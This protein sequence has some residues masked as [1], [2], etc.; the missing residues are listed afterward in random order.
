MVGKTTPVIIHDQ[1]EIVQRAQELSQELGVSIKPGFE[2]F[3]AKVGCEV[4]C[5]KTDEHEWTYIRKDGRCFP[6]M[7]SITALRNAEGNI[8]GFLGI[9]S[10]LTECKQPEAALRLLYEQRQRS[11]Q[12]L[13]LVM[14]LIPQAIW[15][16]DHDSRFLGYNH[17]FAQMVRVKSRDELINKTDYDIWTKEEADLFRA[18]DTRIMAQNRA[19]YNIVEPVSQHKGAWNAL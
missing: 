12:M 19:E 14:D 7:L 17:N 11:Q 18:V 5:E 1:E 16:K 2:V 4:K 15:W 3:V 10:D 13:Q 6:V 9:G 8:T